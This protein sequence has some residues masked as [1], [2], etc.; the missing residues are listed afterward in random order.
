MMARKETLAMPSWT[1]TAYNSTSTG[2]LSTTSSTGNLFQ[3]PVQML[4]SSRSVSV[5]DM[6]T[7]GPDGLLHPM[8]STSTTAAMGMAMNMSPEGTC[9][10][11]MGMDMSGT[12]ATILNPSNMTVTYLVERE[13]GEKEEDEF[14]R[15]DE[16]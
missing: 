11:V 6:V 16:I 9:Y 1:G 12:S 5:G 14:S 15:F 7:M 13:K 4:S 10:Y 3:V 8:T 2:S